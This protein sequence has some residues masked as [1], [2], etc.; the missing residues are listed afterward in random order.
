MAMKVGGEREP[1]RLSAKNWRFFFD[2]AGVG[3]AVAQQR[4]KGMADRFLAAADKLSR[5]ECEGNNAVLPVIRQNYDHLK[6]MR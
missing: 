5:E 6:S 4:L 2:Q 3:Q 1:R